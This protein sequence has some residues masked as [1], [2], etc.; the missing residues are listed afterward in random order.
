[1]KR[2]IKDALF[3]FL[4]GTFCLSTTCVLI[5]EERRKVK[6]ESVDA[7]L[8][9]HTW[10]KADLSSVELLASKMRS[11]RCH[12]PSHASSIL[13]YQADL[14]RCGIID[15]RAFLGYTGD[16]AIAFNGDDFSCFVLPGGGIQI[17]PRNGVFFTN[18]VPPLFAPGPVIEGDAD[19]VKFLSYS[20]FAEAPITG[21]ELCTTWVASSQQLNVASHP[22]NGAV[23]DPNADPR[24]ASVCFVTA[25]L[26]LG[27]TFDWVCT[28]EI[29]YARVNR[30]P[31]LEFLFG[32]YAAYVY[33]IPVYHRNSAINPLEDIHTFQTCYNRQ[34]G[35]VTWKLDGKPVFSINQ[36]G[37]RLTEENA[38]VYSKRGHAKP[39]QNPD[40]FKTIDYGGIDTLLDPIGLQGGMSFLTLL[41]YYAPRTSLRQMTFTGTDIGLTRLEANLFRSVPNAGIMGFF[42]NYPHLPP[43]IPAQFTT[44]A[45]D[46]LGPDGVFAPTI[47]SNYRLWGQGASL[48][49]FDYTV[50]I[51]N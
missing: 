4:I 17:T 50:T 7:D 37:M 5:A 33:L 43:G 48:R 39:L 16:F 12:R 51:E 44:D 13:L 41:D 26:T 6:V 40:S 2:Q 46:V 8:L 23:T 42:Y 31:E 22:F 47:P 3:T 20:I 28:N 15:D 19:H 30:M 36:I 21:E 25:E 9:E 18:S 34:K 35:T 1:M 27:V 24:L 45:F 32:N 38:Y 14:T 11:R 49:L 29:I 10:H